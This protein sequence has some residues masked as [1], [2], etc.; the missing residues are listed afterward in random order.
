MIVCPF[1]DAQVSGAFDLAKRRGLEIICPICEKVNN[2]V[3]LDNPPK[4]CFY[5]NGKLNVMVKKKW[6]ENG[7]ED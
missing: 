5:C 3:E 1:C 7:E 4:R 6:R 2:M